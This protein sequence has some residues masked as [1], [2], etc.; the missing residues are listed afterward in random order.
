MFR[1]ISLTRMAENLYSDEQGA[2]KCNTRQPGCEN[3]CFNQFSP[4]SHVRFWGF[5]T[6]ITATPS[7]VFVV[8]AVHAVSKLP[9]P[10][11]FRKKDMKER[12]RSIK[13]C[14]HGI[15]L[16]S[17]LHPYGK[18]TKGSKVE[19]YQ[20]DSETGASKF[21]L[22]YP[23]LE[24]ISCRNSFEETSDHFGKIKK[25]NP[26]TESMIDMEKSLQKTLPSPKIIKSSSQQSHSELLDL[27]DRM[28]GRLTNAYK[29]QCLGRTFLETCFLT[30]QC[31]AFGFEVPE[32]YRCATYPCPNTVDCFTSRPGEKSSMLIYMFFVTILCI[33]L[34]LF[35]MYELSERN[36]CVKG[37]Q[38][39]VRIRERLCCGVKEEFAEDLEWHEDEQA[40]KEWYFVDNLL[41]QSV[42]SGE[43]SESS[44]SDEDNNSIDS[45]ELDEMY[46]QEFEMDTND[47]EANDQDDF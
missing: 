10:K 3:M 45:R 19:K 2:F 13:R 20:T 11:K 44:S 27:I 12:R 14:S 15:L 18:P 22:E 30:I 34:S 6:I 47:Y 32:K 5:Q 17:P 21:K 9:I 33:V 1:I 4:I 31:I 46:E 41:D 26:M 36:S 28:E 40:A 8:Y 39:A 29:M 24:T 23:P 7:I 42:C 35:E 16:I 38:I 25:E 37:K 43:S